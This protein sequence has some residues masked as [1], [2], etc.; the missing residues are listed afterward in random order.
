M[1]A[2]TPPQAQGASPSLGRDNDR[3]LAPAGYSSE[4]IEA[5]RAAG[6]IG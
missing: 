1:L 2:R 6:A 4:E 5:V 3:V